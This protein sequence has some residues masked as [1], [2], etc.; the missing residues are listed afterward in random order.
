MYTFRKSKFDQPLAIQRALQENDIAVFS[1]RDIRRLFSLSPTQ[2]KYFLETY[3]KRGLFTR[4]KKGLY[5]LAHAMPSE[6]VIANALYVPSYISLEYALARFGIIPEMPYAITSVTPK[7]TA[8]FSVNEKTFTYATIKPRAYA[9]YVPETIDGHIVYIAEPEKA[10]VDYA[11]FVAL[12][13]KTMNDRVNISRLNH[14]KIRS[15][16]TLFDRKKLD[17]VIRSLT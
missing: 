10:L 11:Y 5:A 16:A 15:Y 3:T 12:G 1:P 9:G 13:K 2:T 4:L 6:E 17:T 7:T 8:S 14:H